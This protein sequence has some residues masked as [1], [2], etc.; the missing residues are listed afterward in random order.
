VAVAAIASRQA[1]IDSLGLHR[2]LQDADAQ[3]LAEL[4]A[5]RAH[6]RSDAELARTLERFMAP[7]ADAQLADSTLRAIEEAIRQRGGG[8]SAA[9][10]RPLVE[11]I[12]E[13]AERVLGVP[14]GALEPDRALQDY[15]LDSITA[16]QLATRL[17]QQLGT[18]VQPSWFVEWPTC[19]AL[20]EKLAGGTHA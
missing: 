9:A 18:T 10:S 19:A 16:M 17:E 8:G 2:S 11:L 15:G 7:G 13:S 12:G 3:V 6:Q 4:Q 20:A 1:A 14:R 5:F